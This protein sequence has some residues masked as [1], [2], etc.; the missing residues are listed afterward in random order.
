MKGSTSA[1]LLALR[2]VYIHDARENGFSPVRR[3]VENTR[4]YQHRMSRLL[5]IV[6]WVTVRGPDG[7][8]LRTVRPTHIP[9][10]EQPHDVCR[11]AARLHM[12]DVCVV[13]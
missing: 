1:R 10:V 9:L 7:S 4:V 11:T 3:Q 8:G 6:W 2:L 13:R 12:G 5:L